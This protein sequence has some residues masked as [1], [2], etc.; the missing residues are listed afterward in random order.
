[1]HS[2][3]RGAEVGRLISPYE[4]AKRLCFCCMVLLLLCLC[5]R[6][7]CFPGGCRTKSELRL[8]SPCGRF[9]SQAAA[10]SPPDG[11]STSPPAAFLASSGCWK[12]PRFKPPHG[13]S[14]PAAILSKR[15]PLVKV[16]GSSPR[17]AVFSER[18]P[19]AKSTVQFPPP[20][21][22]LSEQEDDERKRMWSSGRALGRASA[23][24]A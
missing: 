19:L 23:V 18:R 7:N 21:G 8:K 1:M 24:V 11:L 5:P 17:S 4:G 14:P 20:R 9:L 13:S 15:P 12:S 2:I 10:A 16:H 6:G 3:E 22:E